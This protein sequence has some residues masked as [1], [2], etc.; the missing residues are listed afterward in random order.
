VTV[1]AGRYG[2]S[3]SHGWHIS[4]LRQLVGTCKSLKTNQSAMQ[5][6][7]ESQACLYRAWQVI[8]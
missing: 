1:Y 3:V 4:K 7:A 2:M 8:R 6:D 5:V